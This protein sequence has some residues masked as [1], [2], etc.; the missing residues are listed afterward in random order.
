MNKQVW[1]NILHFIVLV[2]FQVL[3]LNNIQLSGYVNPYFYV[4]FIL[5]LPFETPKWLLLILGFIM[6]LTIDF[7]MHTEGI[8]AAATTLMAYLRPGTIK[9][10]TGTRDIE[11]GTRPSIADMGFKWFL[12]YSLILVFFHH[13]LLF[14]LE[15]FRLNEFL[16]VLPL[17]L[18]S[19]LVTLV[20]IIL[21]QYIFLK[22]RKGRS[23]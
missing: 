18:I 20:L 12:M 6:G 2:L 5:L 17:I 11:P 22:P 13:L 23:A 4:L 7:F 21:S 3:I 8:N 1:I 15:T 19:T 9:I 14:Y 16:N 10:F